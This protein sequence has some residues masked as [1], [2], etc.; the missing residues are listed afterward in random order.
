M[1]DEPVFP[2]AWLIDERRAQAAPRIRVPD[3]SAQTLVSGYST[4]RIERR[5]A[6]MVRMVARAERKGKSLTPLIEAMLH[7][8]CREKHPKLELFEGE[9]RDSFQDRNACP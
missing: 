4:I 1:N 3:E 6:E 2:P 9:V 5:V 8:Y 7:A